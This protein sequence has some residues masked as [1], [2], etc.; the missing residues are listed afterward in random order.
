MRRNLATC[1]VLG[2]EIGTSMRICRFALWVDT[3]RRCLAWRIPGV[4]VL[5][6]TVP[7]TWNRAQPVLTVRSDGGTDRKI[8]WGLVTWRKLMT[9]RLRERLRLI[10]PQLS[11]DETRAYCECWNLGLGTPF[12][13]AWWAEQD[14]RNVVWRTRVQCNE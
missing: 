6:G 5:T 2:P 3:E 7:V 4:M 11:T 10:K 8:G 14:S 1:L 12:P 9:R 13:L